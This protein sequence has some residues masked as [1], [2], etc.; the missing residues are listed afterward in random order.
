MSLRLLCNIRVEGTEHLPQQGGVLIASNHISALDTLLLPYTILSSQ[1][2]QIVWAPAKEELFRIP[3]VGSILRSWG[4]FPVRRG[5]GDLR[6]MRQMLAHMRTDKMMLFPEGTRSR[7]GQLQAGKRT[8]GKLV[9]LARP[10]VIPT[11][12]LRAEHGSASRRFWPYQRPWM[13]IHYGKPLDL[14][15]FYSMPDSKATSE[16]IVQEIMGAI[17][18]LLY[19]TPQP[20]PGACNSAR[21]DK[22]KGEPDEAAKA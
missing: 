20:S 8:V 3:L 4:A 12:I 6:A 22:T 11:A 15:R 14:Q 2:C 19:N 7:D 9:Y 1:G 18:S 21:S 17:A 13:H 10:T 16:A 5:K